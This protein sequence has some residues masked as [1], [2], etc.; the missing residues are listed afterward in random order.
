MEEKRQEK[1]LEEAFQ[2]SCMPI[3]IIDTVLN[4]NPHGFK[5]ITKLTASG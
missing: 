5:A 4:P 3:S 1:A 2:V